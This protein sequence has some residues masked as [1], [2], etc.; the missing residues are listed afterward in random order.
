MLK[1]V[2]HIE[3][4]VRDVDEMAEFFRRMGFEEV[5][6]TEHHGGAVEMKLPGPDQ[7]IFEFHQMEMQENP[8]VNHIAFL[9]EDSEATVAELKAK[10]MKFD[11]GPYLFQTTGRILTNFRDPQGFRLQFAE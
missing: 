1:R 10:G 7:V 2:D 4:V 3:I 11:K 8:G 5:R 6:R 9:V